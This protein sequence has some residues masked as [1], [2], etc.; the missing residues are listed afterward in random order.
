MPWR[1]SSLRTLFP[2]P[3][4]GLCPFGLKQVVCP[5]DGVRWQLLPIDLKAERNQT[6]GHRRAVKR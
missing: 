3:V 1:M 2:A 4:Y 5:A 6:L